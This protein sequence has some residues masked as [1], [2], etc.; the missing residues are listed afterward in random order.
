MTAFWVRGAHMPYIAQFFGS[1]GLGPP[2]VLGSRPILLGPD[3][4]AALTVV[5]FV[6]SLLL[7]LVA[8]RAMGAPPSLRA[9]AGRAR[10]QPSGWG[11]WWG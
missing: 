11:R 3:I 6:A 10:A 7:A 9:V 1:G 5:C 4:R 8:A 2:D